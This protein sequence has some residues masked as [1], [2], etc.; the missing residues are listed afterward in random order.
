MIANF[1]RKTKPIHAIFIGL[2]FLVFYISSILFVEQPELSLKLVGEKVFGTFLFLILFFLLR[3]VN[4]KNQLSGQDS[5]FLLLLMFLFAMFPRTMIMDRV[6]TAH[7]ILLFSFRR[8]YSIRSLKNVKQKIFDSAF[9]IGVA[10]FIYIWSVIYLLLIA[11]AIFVYKR[12]DIRNIFITIMGFIT[13]WFL[14]FTYYFVS[15]HSEL[16]YNHLLFEYTFSM[17]V[18]RD[19]YY[20]IPMYFTT[21]FTLGALAIVRLKI[22]ALTNDLKPSWILLVSHLLI[23]VTILIL[24][25]EK[26]GADFVFSFFPVAIFSANILQLV[27]KSVIREIIVTIFAVLAILVYFL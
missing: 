17:E 21:I 1:F 27:K 5:Y 18:Y 13:P 4:R 9:W 12:N 14:L 16:F 2:L 11:V 23:G 22:N 10:S 3:F 24:S 15:D 26:N 8:V 20:L 7:F 25:S 6:F 19:A